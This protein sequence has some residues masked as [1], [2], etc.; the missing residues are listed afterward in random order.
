MGVLNWLLRIRTVRHD[1]VFYLV[2]FLPYFI[3]GFAVWICLDEAIFAQRY[4]LV[5]QWSLLPLV[6]LTPLFWHL[7][8]VVLYLLGVVGLLFALLLR[9]TSPEDEDEVTPLKPEEVVW[10][11]LVRP[12]RRFR[13]WLRESPVLVLLGLAGMF[14][15]LVGLG[16]MMVAFAHQ[17][18]WSIISGSAIPCFVNVGGLLIE[19][20]YLHQLGDL[21]V[22]VGLAVMFL[23]VIR[24]RAED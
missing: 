18:H 17:L 12:V 8:G 16:A 3:I 14:F 22:A 19:A 7:F 10:A 9:R 23:V 2:A 5:I 11:R 20:L 6:Q 1:W 24:E 21:S 15:L 4:Q 13:E